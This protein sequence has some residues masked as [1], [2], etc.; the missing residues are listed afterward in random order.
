MKTTIL[1]AVLTGTL[2]GI[3]PLAGNADQHAGDALTQTVD[4]FSTLV[5]DEGNISRPHGYRQNYSHLGSW[6]VKDDENASGPGVHD[7]YANPAAVT[8]YRKTGEWPDGTVLVKEVNGIEKGQKTTGMARWAGETG[9]WFVMIKDSKNRF[10]DNAA[11][12]GGWGWALF[13]QD[14]PET[15]LTKTWKGDGFNN[16]YG[17]HL[18]AKKTDWV[19]VEG[20]PTLKNTK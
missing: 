9:V 1:T 12:G 20:Y 6:F 19:Y 14:S 3:V 18:P 4:A 2:A 16:C 11:W 17:C 7:V 10:P 13:D 8:A 15:S 5:D